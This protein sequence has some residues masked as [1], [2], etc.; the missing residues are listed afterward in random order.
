MASLFG[1]VFHHT[2]WAKFNRLWYANCTSVPAE[3]RELEYGDKHYWFVSLTLGND[4]WLSPNC[5]QKKAL[6]YDLP[7]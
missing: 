1:Y 4:I 6:Q 2:S 5:S 7:F 3:I